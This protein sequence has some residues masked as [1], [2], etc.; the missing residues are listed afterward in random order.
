MYNL[1][2]L[3]RQRFFDANGDPLDSGKLYTYE[4]GTTTLVDTYSDSIGTLNTN[5][6]VL[7]ADGYCDLWLD[8]ISYK[9]K[10]TDSSDAEIWTKDNV[11]VPNISNGFSTGDVKMGFKTTADSGW[12]MMD[13]KTIGNASSS[14]TGRANADTEDL[15]TLLWNNI[16]NSYAAVS[17]GRGA[18]AAVDYA[19]N[20]TIALPKSLGRAFASAG[21]GSGLTSRAL[22]YYMGE[23]DHLLITNEMPSHTHTQDSHYH[24]Q[25]AFSSDTGSTGTGPKYTTTANNANGVNNTNPTTATNQNTGGGA[26][27]NNM[28]PTLFLNVMIKL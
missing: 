14:A 23:E 5:P 17:G 20:K 3:A 15:F 1:S 6:I 21:A 19:A 16:S 25:V 12:V 26:A 4:A 28:Q 18:S 9:L 11:S 2:P 13:D 27:H 22:A 10:L 8:T 24:Q 7:D